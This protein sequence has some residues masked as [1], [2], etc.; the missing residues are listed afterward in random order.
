MT[1]DSRVHFSWVRELGRCTV[2]AYD[3]RTMTLIYWLT[4]YSIYLQE[5]QRLDV[6]TVENELWFLKPL[7]EFLLERSLEVCGVSDGTLKAYREHLMQ[8]ARA[9]VN[10]SA[11]EMAWKRTTNAKLRRAYYFLLWL[12][13]IEHVCAGLIGPTGCAVRSSLRLDGADRTN[14][15]GGRVQQ[16]DRGRF[17][18]LFTHTGGRSRHGNQYEATEQDRR[19]LIDHFSAA[20][21]PYIAQRNIL[22][23]DLADQVGWRRASINSLTC[24][25]FSDARLAAMRDGKLLVIPPKQ[26][27]SYEN[28]Y[29]IDFRIANRVA[30]FLATYRAQFLSERGWTERVT[31]GRIFFSARNGAPLGDRTISLIFGA[32]FR[33]I[34]APRGAGGHSFRRK[35]VNDEI[36]SEIESRLELGLDTSAESIAGS[37]AAAVGQSN[38]ASLGPYVSKAQG[39]LLAKRTRSP[40]EQLQGLKEENDALR[41]ELRDL[42]RKT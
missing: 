24:E 4:D 41:A 36:V 23:M 12:Q 20:S 32:G 29:T 15:A 6:K 38:I 16:S 14:W 28:A 10:G 18:L 17:P 30:N 2:L 34:G 25:Q 3:L 7:F 33:V 26:K 9:A 22:I 13:D 39:R 8:R 40:R 5:D 19:L 31:E 27:F 11:S 42:R 1:T 35:F 21:H 37:V